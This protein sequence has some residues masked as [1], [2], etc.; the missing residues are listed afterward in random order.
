M[1]KFSPEG[2]LA[3]VPQRGRSWGGVVGVVWL[4]VGWGCCCGVGC[5]G[6]D[7]L[8]AKRIIAVAFLVQRL[9]APSA[10]AASKKKKGDSQAEA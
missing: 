1:G 7:N 8:P 10:V 3:P 9:A 2:S 6:W 4:G 5:W